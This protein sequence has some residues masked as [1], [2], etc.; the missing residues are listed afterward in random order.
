[1]AYGATKVQVTFNSNRL[2]HF[3]GVYLF[4]LFLKQIGLRHVIARNLKYEQ[5]NN[6]YTLTGLLFSLLYPVILGLSRIETAKMLGTNGVFKLL[7]GLDR[8]PDPTTLRRFLIRGSDDV[9]PQLV[10]LHDRLRKYF[11]DRIVPGKKLLVD[12]DSTVCTLY[13]HQEGAMK[14]Y[15]PRARGNCSGHMISSNGFS[16]CACHRQ[17]TPR[18]SQ[19][20]DTN[21]SSCLDHSRCMGVDRF[22]VF[23]RML[24]NKKHSG[25]PRKES[26]S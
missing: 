13:G 3:G 25:M 19:P 5:R 12:M 22:F 4:H 2:T 26:A 7:I 24:L 10:R 6:Y 23:Q 14:G 9:L 15:N 16:G 8:F 21:S 11:I 1:M 18:H 17:N 20:C